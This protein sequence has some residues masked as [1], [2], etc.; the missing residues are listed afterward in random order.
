MTDTFTVL[1]ALPQRRRRL[2][3]AWCFLDLYRADDE[4]PAGALDL[5][6]HPH[7]G[8]QTVTWLFSG[9][10]RHRDSLG[11]DVRIRPGELNIMT[12][13]SGIAH[14]ETSIPHGVLHGLQFWIAL[15]DRQRGKAPAF[16]HHAQLPVVDLGGATARVIVGD[17]RGAASP[18]TVYSA[19][20][21]AEIAAS[22]GGAISVPLEPAFEYA[23]LSVDGA[24]TVDGLGSDGVGLIYVGAGREVMKLQMQADARAFLIGGVPLNEPVLLWWNFVARS[25]AEMLAAREEWQGGGRF[26]RV[27]GFGD[28]RI[29]APPL[30]MTLRP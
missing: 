25:T 9:E 3:G 1:R 7:I 11:N 30:T 26:G 27:S 17:M 21:G 13:G 24:V 2:V 4:G 6:P 10:V 8:L 20:V 5:L 18:A 29:D 12:A 15:P 22:T 16:E 28:R 14:A 23:V 19:L